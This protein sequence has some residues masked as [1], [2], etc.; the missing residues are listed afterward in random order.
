VARAL[1]PGARPETARADSARATIPRA[2]RFAAGA[3]AVVVSL[4][5][6][7]G[8]GGSGVQ[9]PRV[10]GT[11]E[12]VAAI[13]PPCLSPLVS[14]CQDQ[15]LPVYGVL[16][17]AFKVGPDF[18]RHPRL[19]S[20][21]DF[22]TKPPFTLTYHIRPE[23]R[24]SDGTAITAGDFLFTYRARLKFPPLGDDNL[25][26]TRIRSIRAIDAKTVSVVLRSRFAVWRD[27]FEIVLPRHA[28]RGRDPGSIW[29]DRIDDPRTGR[30]I[31]SGPFLVQRWERG[32]QLTL[33]RNPRWWGAHP[34]YLDRIVVR[35][36]LDPTVVADFF[37]QSADV[38]QWQF[39]EDLVAALQRVSDIGLRLAP[40]T[41]GWEHFDIRVGPGGHP[42]LKNKLVRRALA[43]A[44]DRVALVR[45]LFGE[46]GASLRPLDSVLLRSGH[47]SYRPNWSVYQYRPAEARRM[48]ERAGCRR[49]GDGIYSC[50]G[51]RLALRFVSRG[52]LARRVQ[53]LELVQAQLRQAGVQVVPS[54]ASSLGHNQVLESGD[55]DVTLFA[56]FS[57]HGEAV[58]SKELYG[59]GGGQNHIG[60]CQRLLT[61]DLDQADRIIDGVARARVLNRADVQLAKDVPTIPLFEV[62]SLAAVRSTVRNFT[63]SF[64]FTDPTWNAENWWLE[65]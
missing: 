22:T 21:V 41:P 53:T 38:G 27:L 10:G 52:A 39:S 58:A 14:P 36:S 55:F 12:I 51:E 18:T 11:L 5:A 62:P 19:V 24:W 8:A 64:S 50:Q 7:S 15:I 47:R 1:I 59:C 28:L 26:E 48:L 20:H 23:A 54:Y 45:A 34:A 35:Y 31:G 43:Y 13:E 42:A 6:V 60:Y 2:G 25:Y 37:R 65:R 61:R 16:E 9:T 3:A 49:G 30:P 32:K 40:D 4:L 46:T 63:S 17:G 33:V 29:T 44:I 56:W 57:N